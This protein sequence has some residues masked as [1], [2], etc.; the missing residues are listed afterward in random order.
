MYYKYIL[1]FQLSVE[2]KHS[3]FHRQRHEGHPANG[4]KQNRHITR[5]RLTSGNCPTLH[6][7]D[8]LGVVLGGLGS[9]DVKR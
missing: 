5:C 7:C 9:R 1:L 6:Q 8:N 2:R 4:N 3:N